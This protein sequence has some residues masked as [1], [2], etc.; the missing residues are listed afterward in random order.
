M[1]FDWREE[2]AM[3]SFMLEN[4]ESAALV[5]FNVLGKT[6]R[7]MLDFPKS[8]PWPSAPWAFPSD[9]IPELNRHLLR[10]VDILHRRSRD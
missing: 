7:H 2:A 3:K 1:S 8:G 5:R 4:D 6:L 10:S 9:R